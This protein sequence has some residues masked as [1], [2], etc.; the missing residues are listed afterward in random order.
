MGTDKLNN[1]ARAAGFAMAWFED[2]TSSTAK[3]VALEPTAR[4]KAWSTAN[5]QS[6]QAPKVPVKPATLLSNWGLM[7]FTFWKTA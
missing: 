2:A 1:T 6:A 5:W 7:G 3:A 4:G